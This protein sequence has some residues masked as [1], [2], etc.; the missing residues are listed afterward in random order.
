MHSVTIVTN[1]LTISVICSDVCKF[2]KR[3]WVVRLAYNL[4]NIHKK[5]IS[6]IS[7]IFFFQEMMMM[8]LSLLFLLFLW[9]H[10]L[11]LNINAFLCKLLIN[12]KKKHK[13]SEYTPLFLTLLKIQLYLIFS[14]Y[15]NIYA[16]VF[17]SFFSFIN[18]MTIEHIIFMLVC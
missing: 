14:F 17:V 15:L 9:I 16:A 8:T 3:I 12:K 4:L 11:K 7:N 6:L 13:L 18:R 5:R 2:I 1:A 10:E